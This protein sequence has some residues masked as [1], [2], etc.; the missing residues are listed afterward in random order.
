MSRKN[1]KG[2]CIWV[3]QKNKPQMLIDLLLY[4]VLHDFEVKNS[5]SSVKKITLRHVQVVSMMS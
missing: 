1:Q 5:I 3:P 2:H 4:R